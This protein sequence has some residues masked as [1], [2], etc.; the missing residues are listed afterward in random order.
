MFRVLLA[1]LIGGFV[2]HRGYYS[3]K[4]APPPG[5]TVVERKESA[6][7]KVL[8]LLALSAL[9]STAVIACGPRVWSGPGYRCAVGGW[10]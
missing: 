6:A 9:L 7:E 8:G 5:A 10:A 3:R 4:L 1:L 2:A